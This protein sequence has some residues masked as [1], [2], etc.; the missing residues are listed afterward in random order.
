MKEQALKE[1][2]EYGMIFPKKAKA[3]KNQ[4]NKFKSLDN[5]LKIFLSKSNPK[6]LHDKTKAYFN[7]YLGKY[8]KNGTIKKGQYIG[9][10]LKEEIK[11][12]SRYIAKEKCIVGLLNKENIYTPKFHSAYIQKMIKVFSEIKNKFFI[13]EHIEDNI[14]YQNYI[15][16]MHYHKYFKGEKIFL[17]NSIYE[18]IYLLIKGSIKI[19]LNTSIDEMHNSMTYLTFSLNNF[20][21]YISGF[22]TDEL[23]QLNL[24][25]CLLNQN[26]EMKYL[27][28][29]K[30]DYDLM[31]IKEYNII[32]T[33]EAYE[34]QTELY[35]FTAEC[36]SDSA[37]LYFFP[38]KYLNILLS[39]EKKMYIILIFI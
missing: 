15:P 16:Y 1:L 33:N 20:N 9:S 3:K 22:K 34:H 25:N 5:Y 4:N 28:S 31:T 21:D 6:T 32:G 8:V 35:N 38:K 19:S 14:F 7:F 17:Q 39:K 30:D 2:K 11:D 23:T 13:F 18:G 29:K 24:K 36:I 26:K 10:F 37:V 27:Y 12:S